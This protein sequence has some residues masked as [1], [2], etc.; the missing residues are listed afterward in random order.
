MRRVRRVQ[1]LGGRQVALPP[2]TASCDGTNLNAGVSVG[3]NDRAGLERLCRNLLR[4]PLSKE[5]L[6]RKPDGTIVI[7]LGRAWSDGTTAIE[8][9][10]SELVL[11]TG[12]EAL[13]DHSPSPGKTHHLP[14]RSGAQ[15]GVEG[16][17][18]PKPPADS[19]AARTAVKLA[20]GSRINDASERVP[21]AEL[22]KRVFKEGVG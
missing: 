9:S 5:R 10:P 8:L 3:A 18:I 2:R 15:R 6:E 22:L 11:Q 14:R 4:P 19:R 16:E 7:G 12:W 1:T 21:W 17:V 13:R 20:R